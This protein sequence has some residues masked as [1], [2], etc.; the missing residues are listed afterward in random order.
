MG[1]LAGAVGGRN[2]V[3]DV[4]ASVSDGLLEDLNLDKVGIGKLDWEVVSHEFSEEVSTIDQ[5]KT[6]YLRPKLQLF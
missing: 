5:F 2:H 4:I 6:D 3:S 1:E